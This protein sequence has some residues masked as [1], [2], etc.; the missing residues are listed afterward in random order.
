M[1]CST[2]L[3]QLLSDIAAG[4]RVA[5]RALYD[6]TSAFLLSVCVRLLRDRSRAE[7]ALQ[8][9]FV[10]IWERA[11]TFDPAKGGA[12]TW[13]I[14]LTRRVA[15][16]ELRRTYPASSQ[17]S[18]E[19][20]ETSETSDDFTEC[21]PLATARLR[22]CLQK[23]GETQREAII[24]AYVYGFTTEELANRFDHPHG[25]IKSWLFRSLANLR[26]CLA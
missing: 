26:K 16:N 5:F 2:T 14:V 25:T 21:D 19:D 24:M 17:I 20:A 1:Q 4:D 10:R 3:E 18:M 8:E 13:L 6:R 15:I 23:L 7:E 11:R 12:M 22:S 9:A